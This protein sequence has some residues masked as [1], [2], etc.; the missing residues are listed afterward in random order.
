MFVPEMRSPSSARPTCAA[1]AAKTGRRYS[2]QGDG[3]ALVTC[4]RA[5]AVSRGCPRPRVGFPDRPRISRPRRRRSATSHL[6]RRRER[7]KVERSVLIDALAA[8]QLCGIPAAAKRLDQSGA[9]DETTLADIDRR[10][11]VGQRGLIGDDDAR[12]RDGAGQILVIEDPR[13]LECCRHSLVLHLG[14]LSEDAQRRELVLDLLES[15]QHALPVIRDGLL[16]EGA[17]LFY[18]SGARAGIEHCFHKGRSKRPEAARSGQQTVQRQRRSTGIGRKGDRRIKR[19]LGNADLCIGRRHQPL[20]GGNVGAALQKRGRHICRYY[21]HRD[22]RFRRENR[23]LRRRLADQDRDRV[24]ELGTRHT[25]RN[26]LRLRALELRLGLR[27]GRLVCSA[28]LILVARDPQRFGIVRG[29]GV[30]QALQLVRDP[31]LQIVAGQRALCCKTGAGEIAG[32]RLGARHIAFD[33]TADLTP[34]VRRPARRRGVAE[35]AAGKPGSAGARAAT[36]ATAGSR[37][38]RARIQIKGRE[39][40]GAGLGDDPFR[41][42][43]R[44]FGGFEVLIGNVDLLFQIVEY[45]IFVDRP[46]GAA[47]DRIA[48]LADFPARFL[49]LARYRGVG[50]SVIGADCA[51]RENKRY[52][53]GQNRPPPAP[54]ER[55]PSAASRARGPRARGRPPLTHPALW[56]GSSLTRIVEE[57][58]GPPRATPASPAW[59]SFARFERGSEGKP[60]VANSPAA[61]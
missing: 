38:L 21:R 11:G 57:G 20:G 58:F 51:P 56:A 2:R 28:A 8:R 7:A 17:R 53:T 18:D 59:V 47:V 42:L 19:R 43:K 61:L 13:G 26:R 10:H 54:K 40:A 25:D 46:P 31:E 30:E 44:G 50:Q 37:T 9:G 1:A 16:E 45:G 29:C 3:I 22:H 34:E 5:T 39:K 60:V 32:A 41:L 24:L 6:R 23:K 35:R 33:S 27:D 52:G 12:I 49:V 4:A 55:V 36:G 15:G 14:L 48:R